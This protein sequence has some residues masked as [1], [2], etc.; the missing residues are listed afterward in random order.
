MKVAVST[1]GILL[2]HPS[3]HHHVRPQVFADRKYVQQAN[4]PQ[5]HVEAIY[6]VTSATRGWVKPESETNKK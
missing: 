4:N 1:N 2:Y 6:H 5:H 3:N